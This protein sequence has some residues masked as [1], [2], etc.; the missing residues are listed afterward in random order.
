MFKENLER[1]SENSEKLPSLFSEAQMN[2]QFTV[3]ENY[4][5]ANIHI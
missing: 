1:K 4:D 5:T 3:I 2:V